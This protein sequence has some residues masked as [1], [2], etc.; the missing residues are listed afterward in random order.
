MINELNVKLLLP[1][2]LGPVYPDAV[3]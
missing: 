3:A 1:W 2:Q